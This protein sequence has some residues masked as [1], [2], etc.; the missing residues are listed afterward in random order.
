MDNTQNLVDIEFATMQLGGNS[1]LLARM[2]GK[3]CDEFRSTPQKVIDALAQGNKDEAKLTVHTTKGL[4]GNLGLIALFECSKVLDQQL[5]EDAIDPLQVEA[6][7][8]IMQDTIE[9]IKTLDL[10]VAVPATFKPMDNGGD[11]AQKAIFLT[12]LERNEFID[13]DTLY[14]YINALSFDEAE[15]QSLKNLVEELQ[16]DKAI[17]MIKQA[18]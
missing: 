11:I 15:K 2:L 6:F 1:D 9:F 4:S 10:S 17:A 7:S 12:R 16:Y 8:H 3:F 13:D 14:I 5:R 18:G